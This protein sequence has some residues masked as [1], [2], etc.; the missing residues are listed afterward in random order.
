MNIK[1]DKV[2]GYSKQ[3]VQNKNINGYQKEGN[4]LLG[5][6]NNVNAKISESNKIRA[7]RSDS[8]TIEIVKQKK[9]SFLDKLIGFFL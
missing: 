7:F 2:I 1:T 5:F 6:Y 9:I 8:D 4:S 3:K